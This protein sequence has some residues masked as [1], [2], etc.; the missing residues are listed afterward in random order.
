MKSTIAAEEEEVVEEVE[1]R[2]VFVSTPPE[3]LP[4]QDEVNYLLSSETEEDFSLTGTQTEFNFNGITKDGV[5]SDTRYRSP[6]DGDEKGSGGKKGSK[7]TM[8]VGA[9]VKISE[10]ATKQLSSGRQ[11]KE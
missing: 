11:S 5:N 10:R 1:Q 6:R 9:V 4:T 7:K 8:N 2:V 3:P